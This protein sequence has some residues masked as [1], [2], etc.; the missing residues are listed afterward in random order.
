MMRL[1]IGTA[2]ALALGLALAS[3]AAADCYADYKAKQ[4]RPLRLH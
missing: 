4:D 3:P 2:T 1:L